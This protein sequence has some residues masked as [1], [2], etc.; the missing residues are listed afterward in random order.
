MCLC[1]VWLRPNQDTMDRIRAQFA[2]L[3][4]KPYYRASEII[5]RGKNIGHNPWQMDHQ[6]AMD[7]KSGELKRGK[8]TSFL[9]R[10]Q[11][12]EVFRASQLVHGWTD[13]W[14]KYLD[15]WCTL[16]TATTKWKHNLFEKRRFQ[17][18]S[19]TTVST[20][21]LQ[22][23]SKY[24]CQLS[25]SSRQRSTSGTNAFANRTKYHIGSR[26]S[27]TLRMVEFQ[28][29]DVFLVIFILNMDR[30]P[31]VVDEELM[32]PSMARMEDK[33]WWDQR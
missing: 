4:K 29:V 24:F 6:K 8:C 17:E 7:A 20:T 1:R 27:T 33:E 26:S 5:S 23:I 9:D 13:E 28:L 3:K 15:P 10:W 16:P 2:A 32:G 12:D 11:N 14:V 31:N 30:K 25:T 19:R 21:W 18:T 22:I